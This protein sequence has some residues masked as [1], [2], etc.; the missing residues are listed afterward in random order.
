M[1]TFEQT[2]LDQ[3]PQPPELDYYVLL[4]F[5]RC[6][7]N[8]DQ[9]QSILEDVVAQHGLVSSQDMKQARREVE[10]SGGSFDTAGWVEQQL[11]QIGHREQWQDIAA[12][13]IDQTLNYSTG[14]N[15]GV[16]MPG[17][18]EL[19]EQFDELRIP[20]GFLTFGSRA[21]QT[22]KLKAAGQALAP[23]LIVDSK[24]KG[25]L[26]KRWQQPDGQ[27]LLPAELSSDRRPFYVKHLV[28]LDDKPVS[29]A[30]APRTNTTLIHVI[31][32]NRQQLSSQGGAT[33]PGVYAAKGL[34][35]AQAILELELDDSRANN[36]EELDIL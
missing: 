3:E 23:Q 21:W 24:N 12:D 31:D 26:L 33:P 22:T 28:F 32:P 27:F 36:H 19:I 4:D 34:N 29:F 17:A 7:G 5:D 10:I 14:E 20:Y 15:S 2:N 9:L 11:A 30:D 13:F 1:N 16:L 6:I 25:E 18:V 35:E 8:T